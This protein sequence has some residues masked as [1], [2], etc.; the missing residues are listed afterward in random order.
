MQTEKQSLG[1]CGQKKGRNPCGTIDFPEW[2]SVRPWKLDSRG[3]SPHSYYSEV[4]GGGGVIDPEFP[5]KKV[6]EA[7]KRK[8]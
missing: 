3:T 7:G 1:I 6:A 2:L 5:S 8:E 4:K